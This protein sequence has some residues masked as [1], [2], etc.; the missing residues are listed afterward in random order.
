MGDHLYEEITKC[1]I[2]AAFSVHNAL[3]KGLHEKTYENALVHKIR[4]LGLKVEQQKSLPVLFEDVVVGSQRIDML[5]EGVVLVEVKS[6]GTMSQ[7][8][9][10]QVLGYLKN[11]NIQLGLIINFGTKVEIKRLILTKQNK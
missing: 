7:N 5:V 2:G 3:G 4:A 1:I 11:T 8:H 10:S 9:V 6:V